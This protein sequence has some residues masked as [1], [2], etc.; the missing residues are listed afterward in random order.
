MLAIR[1]LLK[2]NHRELQ[3]EIRKLLEDFRVFERG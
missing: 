3:T 1:Q 2:N